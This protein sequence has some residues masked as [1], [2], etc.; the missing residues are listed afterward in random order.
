MEKITFIVDYGHPGIGTD[1]LLF[2]EALNVPGEVPLLYKGNQQ[3]PITRAKLFMDAGVLKAIAA[4]PD[5]LLDCSP[6]LAFSFEN[7]DVETINGIR[8][9]SKF[10]IDSVSLIPGANVD[11]NVKPI[12]LQGI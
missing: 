2:N 11:P 12:R 10:R 1:R 3:R 9:F 6:S 5:H 4:I 8:V 7:A